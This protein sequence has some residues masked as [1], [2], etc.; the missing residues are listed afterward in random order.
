MKKIGKILSSVLAVSMLISS[1][2]MS[3]FA[4][5]P[6]KRTLT[7]N[8]SKKEGLTQGE[9]FTVEIAIDKTESLSAL[10]YEL[11]YDKDV[12]EVDSTTGWMSMKDFLNHENYIDQTW[13]DTMKGEA[14]GAILSQSVFN[15]KTDHSIFAAFAG[16]QGIPSAVNAT[17]YV[18]GKF[19]FKVKSDAANGTYEFSLTGSSGD[20]GIVSSTDINS[21]PVNVTV[22]QSTTKAY[23][24]AT[25]TWGIK[26]KANTG[27]EFIFDGADNTAK[28]PFGSVSFDDETEVKVGL[29]VTDVPADATLTLTDVDWYE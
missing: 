10:D 12:F 27:V 18:V 7:I 23:F 19:N 17:N 24:E 25:L 5:E 1:F 28:V 21:T 4:A 26:A 20:G 2:A 16:S 11:F 3:A 8:P 6:T 29:E 9:A 15:T 22:G 14:F 13:Y